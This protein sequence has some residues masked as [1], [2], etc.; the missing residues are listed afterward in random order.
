MANDF[1]KPTIDSLP[2]QVSLT[3]PGRYLLRQLQVAFNARSMAEVS[4]RERAHYQAVKNW[5]GKYKPKVNA[6]NLEQ[7]RGYLEAFHHFYEVK[8]GCVSPSR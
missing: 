4:H 7:V 2:E 1:S 6:S 3:H 8:E 5:S